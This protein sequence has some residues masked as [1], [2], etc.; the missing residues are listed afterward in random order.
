[1]KFRLLL[2]A[3][4]LAGGA[5]SAQNPPPAAP[6]APGTAQE[7]P[8]LK[9][10]GLHFQLAAPPD[11]LFAHD[12]STQGKLPGVKLDVKSYL[13]HEYAVLPFP[14]KEFTVTG[15]AD[16][17]DLADSG[18]VLAKVKLPDGF[19]N[20]IFIFLPGTGKAG[21]P[22]FRVL[23]IDDANRLFPPGS[24]RITNLSPRPVRIELE[25]EVFNF[26]S[27]ETRVIEDPPVSAS[28]SSGMRG[29]AQVDG[30]WTRFASTIWPHPGEK[31]SIQLIFEDPKTR[32]VEI[33]GIRDIA[34]SPE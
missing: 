24:F 28:N 18:K 13:N 27:G 2:T 14:G 12:P 34:G 19:K 30:N 5:V 25:K 21:D 17:T 22:K 1:M 33:H 20:G 10:R 3:A 31:R 32:Q 6:P 7:A 15:S 23:V 29:F 11:D 8:G 4:L 9:I 26:R 16:P